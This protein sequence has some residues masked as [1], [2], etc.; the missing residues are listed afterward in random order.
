MQKRN[1]TVTQKPAPPA[2]PGA[3]VVDG[4]AYTLACDFNTLADHE[5][6]TGA[7][8][9]HAVPGILLNVLSA[10]Q[11]RG[12]L[13]AALQKHHPYRAAT[14]ESAESGISWA[15]A[16]AMLRVETLPEVYR[17]LGE[18]DLVSGLVKKG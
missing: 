15:A 2:A 8:L 9:L 13:Y 12:L 3:L 18:T 7:N 11:L 6:A 5:P 14:K 1:K 16:G 17:A 10:A 4:K